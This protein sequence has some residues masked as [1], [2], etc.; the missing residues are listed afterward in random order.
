MAKK[1]P[2]AD[3]TAR[4]PADDPVAAQVWAPPDGD[5]V[6]NSRARYVWVGTDR[7]EHVSEAPDGRWV[8]RK[9]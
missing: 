5:L 6:A 9:S 7:Y 8:Y 4:T 3:M 1:A 2:V